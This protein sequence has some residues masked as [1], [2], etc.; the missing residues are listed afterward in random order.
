MDI[1][2][3][4]KFIAVQRKQL[5]M[6][7][8]NLADKLDITNKAVSKWETG[9]GYP[10]ISVLPALA[11][12]LGVT[13]DE[14]LKGE[15]NDLSLDVNNPYCI[16]ENKQQAAYL[17]GKRK[18]HFANNY[19]IS[20]G[21]LF[22]GIIAS[23]LGLRLYN[24]FHYSSLSY[25][26]MISLSFLII[27]IMFYNNSCKGFESDIEKYNSMLEDKKVDFNKII[28]KKHILFYAVYL[29]QVVIL[30]CVIP[31]YPFRTSAYYY[32]TKKIYG[33]SVNDGRF[34]IDYDF[35]Y[36]L[37]LIIYC[38]LL[39]VGILIITKKKRKIR[40]YYDS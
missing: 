28:Y 36:V 39:C 16:K 8:Q 26:T 33:Y 14:I 7:Q 6:T 2:K 35:F 21:I 40:Q 5:S 29:I 15:K 12:V 38:I 13:I 22:I 17:L 11:E 37:N 1:K 27:G 18:Q 20:I 32:V 19:L 23:S 24:G 30:F 10:D 25:S 34:R 3:I 9:E 31:L 4:G